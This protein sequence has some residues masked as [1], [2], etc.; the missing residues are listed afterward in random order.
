MTKPIQVW[1][2]PPGPNPWKV[3]VILEELQ[4]PYEIKSI[5]FENIKKKPFTDLNPNG[6]VPAIVDPNADDLVVWESGAIITYLCEQ[7]DPEKTLSGRSVSE[8]AHLNQW[9][10][11]QA[12]G[13]GPYFGQAGWFNNHHPEKLPSA[14]E[15]YNKEVHRVLGVLEACLEGKQWLVGDRLTFVDIAFAPWNDRLEDVTK[16]APGDG[17]KGFPNVQAWHER[18][19]A[20]PAWKKSMATKE[21]LMDEQDL[22][23]VGLPKGMKSLQEW[24]KQIKEQDEAASK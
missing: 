15:R 18:V 2:A 21:R 9:L 11:F 4:V 22:T 10:Y 17:F 1:M 24:E 13:Q 3:V 12:S 14:M 16:C 23:L 7:Y 20:R 8:R 6:R 5:R 19:T